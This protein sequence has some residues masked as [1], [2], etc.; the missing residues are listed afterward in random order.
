MLKWILTI[1]ALIC[2]VVV[3]IMLEK[4][5]GSISGQLLL[6][7][8]VKKGEQITYSTDNI[9]SAGA[10]VVAYGSVVRG[11]YVDAEGRYKFDNIPVGSYR[12]QAR[13]NGYS[14]ETSWDVTVKESER[15]Q[16]EKIK[17]NFQEPSLSL[18]SEIRVFTSKERPRFWART[19][20]IKD[21]KIEVYD[22]DPEKFLQYKDIKLDDRYSFLQESY[23]YGSYDKIAG[24]I[25]DKQP[26]KV[27]NKTVSYGLEDYANANFE[28][29]DK[30]SEGSYLVKASGYSLKDNSEFTSYLWFTV[31]DLGIVTKQDRDRLLV[32][33]VNLEDLK[34]MSDVD[35]KFY[36]KGDKLTYLGSAKTNS[37]GLVS[38]PLKKS[39][40]TDSNSIFVVA[41]KANNIALSGSYSWYYD[42][43][44]Y[45][46]YLY[47]DR[48][49]YRPNQTVYFKGILRTNGPDGPVNMPNQKVTVSIH[50][51]D[52]EVVKTINLKTNA[53]GTYNGLVTI[54]ED[55]KL[56]SYRIETKINDH[57]YD[58]FFEVAEYRKPE[59]KVEVFPGTQTI[60]G[61]NPT[62]VTIKATYFFGYPV[63]NAKVKYTI[64]ASPDYYLKW[65]LM[66]RPEYY[67]YYDDWDEET[68]W[69]VTY[70]YGSSSGEIVAEGYAQTDENGEAKIDINTKPIKDDSDPNSINPWDEYLPQEYKVEA[71]VTDISRKTAVGSGKF[72]V[73]P[74]DFMLFTDTDYYVYTPDQE[75]KVNLTSLGF[76]K[77]P[78][79]TD[80][81]VQLQAWS[82]DSENDQ[83]KNPKVVS[84]TKVK[85]D[86]KGVAVAKLKL[87]RNVPTQTYRILASAEDSNKNKIYTASYVWI[88]NV[89][90]LPASGEPKQSMQITL[91]KKVY[92]PGDKAKLMII[93]PVKNVKA[94]ICMEGAR[95]Y[96]YKLVDIT[97]HN[98]LV[99]IPLDK[100]YVPNAY[101]SVSLIGPKKQYYEQS[102]IVKVSPDNSFLKITL[103]PDKTKYKPRETVK[104]N[105]KVVDA[106]N[107]PVSA[108]LSFGV[109]DESIYALREDYTPDIRKFFFNKRYNDV[110]TSYSFKRTYSAGGDKIQP[111]LRKDFKD[112]AFWRANVTTNN[113]GLATVSFKVPDNLTTWRTTVRAVTKD[114]KVASAIDKILVTKD[115][116][117]R[118]ALPRFYTV[119]DK[120]LLATIVHNYTDKPQDIK[121][122]L[123]LPKNLVLSDENV[124]PEV[125][126][127]VPSQGQERKDWEI[128]AKIAGKAKVQAYALSSKIEGDALEQQIETIPYGVFKADID[129]GILSKPDEDAVVEG[130][131]QNK[132]VPGSYKWNLRISASNASVLLGSLDYLVDYPY[133]CTEQIMSKFLPSIIAEKVSKDLGISL[134]PKTEKKLPKVVAESLKMLYQNQHSDGGWG[135]WTFDS[136]NPYMTAY[137]LYGFK[138]AKENKHKVDQTRIN[139]AVKW[140]KDYI[141]SKDVLNIVKNPKDT[142]NKKVNDVYY[143]WE[144]LSNICYA[145]Y[146][147]ALYDYK[148]DAVL[149]NLYQNKDLLT[150]DQ[151]AYLSLTYAELGNKK[152]ARELVDMILGRTDVTLSLVSFG[153]NS[154]LLKNLGIT[155]PD[156]YSYNTTEVTAIC[157]RALLKVAPDDTLKDP[158]ATYI[159]AN[160]SGDYWENT[161]TTSTVILA[162]S[163]YVKNSLEKENP[164]YDVEVK[165]AGKTLGKY[166]FDKSTMFKPE[167]VIEIPEK[168][169]GKANKISIVKTG[170][171]KL[172]YN[173]DLS[174]YLL[175]EPSETIPEVANKGVKIT[176]TL[177]RLQSS[178]DSDG[179]IS[180]KEKPLI[181][182]VKAGE[183][184]LVKLEIDNSKNAKYLLIEDPK[185][186]G[187]ELIS[188]DPRAVMGSDE[189]NSDSDNSNY[190]WNFWW[191]HQEDRD[192]HMS[193]FVTE[194]QPGKHTVNYIVRPEIPGKYLINPTQLTG[195]YSNALS[196]STSSL[197]LTVEE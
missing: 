96:N 40:Q 69:G 60:V 126:V 88:S 75:V 24:V 179:N 9:K 181:G 158:I 85:T 124:K 94:L 43:N 139:N 93:S 169:V 10:Y 27:L 143:S 5:T 99:E 171:G 115:I 162:L 102:S 52:D 57:D 21:V 63:A 172:Y 38:F 114:T 187:M 191:T 148:N 155:L 37:E 170:S 23:Y 46:V 2:L 30:L 58:S 6:A 29:S 70:D 89:D 33:S 54:P 68:P 90:S 59:Y 134:N 26:I 32:R 146:V 87:S 161:K 28:L 144:D 119:G 66:P 185:S 167:T 153:M 140:L 196:G 82:W 42:Y 41:K 44:K 129:S 163:E 190:W 132:I 83:Y 145:S 97:S 141:N 15:T 157:L 101:V 194:L 137:V 117:I 193:F 110:N 159:F 147:L 103:K 78:V 61:G 13:A 133:G 138:Y 100:K 197:R 4:P 65:K 116:I 92:L 80:V 128:E 95:I 77:L 84:E 177:Y 51:I 121:M 48:P 1:L 107:K 150:N 8:V 86:D 56:G 195:M 49:I 22:F 186:S 55:A 156:M 152:Q 16:P 18:S 180:Y 188:T 7:D 98:Q 35:V 20:A 47:T 67:D 71:E 91:D 14:S 130:N 142:L 81:T 50:N 182:K 36:S 168:L 125:F 79:S 178:T 34:N 189:S 123:K 113:K 39:N 131:I 109:V 174:Y 111:L 45:K 19:S 73:V 112:T 127:N 184:I 25:K 17:L 192:T 136:S 173:S 108:D 120:A 74:G 53:F 154:T 175:Y 64:Y 118:L 165:L 72:N 62:K 183:M 166:H 76:N 12:L 3:G 135:W 105:I 160:R 106:D 149:D 151:L 176:K 122:E 104:Y 11:S 31:S 164:D